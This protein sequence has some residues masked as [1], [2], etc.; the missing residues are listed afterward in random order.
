[1]HHF[2]IW[3]VFIDIWR[4][5]SS[6]LLLLLCG[7]GLHMFIRLDFVQIPDFFRADPVIRISGTIPNCVHLFTLARTS[8]VTAASVIHID[9]KRKIPDQGCDDPRCAQ[10]F[11]RMCLCEVVS[12][13]LFILSNLFYISLIPFHRNCY[14][15]GSVRYIDSGRPGE[16]LDPRFARYVGRL[17]HSQ[18]FQFFSIAWRLH[19]GSL[20]LF[21]PGC[22]PS[23]Q[24]EISGSSLVE[25]HL[26]HRLSNLGVP[27]GRV[28]SLDHSCLFFTQRTYNTLA[29]GSNLGVHCYADDG[30]LYLYD[31]ARHYRAWYPKS[32]HA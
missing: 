29:E 26:Q 19:M 27:Q 6:V 24:I 5:T 13:T 14:L 12:I 20:G 10:V 22:A 7:Q 8:V 32:C 1:M 31:R 15:K 21:F 28:V 2:H 3:Y 30:Q 9:S 16:G 4:I 11:H 25:A 18:S 17:Q 23:S